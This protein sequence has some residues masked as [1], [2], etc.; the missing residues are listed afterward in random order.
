MEAFEKSG[1][2]PERE[3]LKERA[4]DAG[5][6]EAVGKWLPQCAVDER[7]GIELEEGLNPELLKRRCKSYDQQHK[8]RR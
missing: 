5:M 6:H 7:E 1:Q 2:K 3:Q 8:E 4:D